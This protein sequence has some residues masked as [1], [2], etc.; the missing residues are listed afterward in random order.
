MYLREE[1]LLLLCSKEEA[2]HPEEL[3]VGCGHFDL[4]Q[5][6]VEKVYG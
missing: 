6:A 4:M 3:Q 2:N 1:T 5:G